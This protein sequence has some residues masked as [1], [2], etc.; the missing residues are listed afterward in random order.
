M[1]RNSAVLHIYTGNGKGKTTA[2]V[3]LSVRAVGAG[4]RV[5]F[6][7]FLKDGSTSECPMLERLGV[8]LLFVAQ[9]EQFTFRM[10]AEQK[11]RCREEHEALLTRIY[12][13]LEQGDY[14]LVVLDEILDAVNT[15]ILEEK[16]LMQLVRRCAAIEVVVTGRNPSSELC[17]RADYISQMMEIKH[18]YQRGIKARKGIEY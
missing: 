3:G 10:N 17:D 2:A 14:Q 7:Q 12:E 8:K 6:C 9:M 4:L 15:G 1:R 5:L 16:Q 13:E 11:A 18:P